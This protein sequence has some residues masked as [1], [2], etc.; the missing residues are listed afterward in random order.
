[1]AWELSIYILKY[2]YIAKTV[3]LN[4]VLHCNMDIEGS[5]STVNRV[6]I[7]LSYD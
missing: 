5:D 2:D 3:S 4:V 7:F 6:L 1:M